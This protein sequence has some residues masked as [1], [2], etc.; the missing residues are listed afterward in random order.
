MN[1]KN[2]LI[3]LASQWQ[4]CCKFAAHATLDTLMIYYYQVRNHHYKTEK[5][6]LVICPLC[7]TAGDVHMSIQQK[8]IWMLGPMAPSSKYAIAY[9]EHCGNYIPKVKWT[10]DMDI[11]YQPLK[12]GLVT[13]RRLYRGLWV[14]P[15]V[16][17]AFVG[18]ILLVISITDGR[19]RS[20]AAAVK[21]AIANPHPGDVF[22][23][24]RNRSNTLDYTYLKVTRSNGD[25]LYLLPSNVHLTDRKGWNDVPTEASAYE[26][27]PMVFSLS[28]SAAEEMFTYGDMPAEYNM[29]Y[30]VWKNGELIK[31]Y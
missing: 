19:Q 25:S 8:Y 13:P 6:P 28:K 29:V 27:Q 7:R 22:Q 18:I 16:V 24:I 11:V 31:K 12:K 4:I 17:A 30:G 20:N 3:N 9:C 23:V 15:L 2:I 1:L 21:E 26:A 5:V 10:N 14:F